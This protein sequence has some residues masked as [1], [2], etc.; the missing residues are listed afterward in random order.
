[1]VTLRCGGFVAVRGAHARARWQ[2]QCQMDAWCADES[3]RAFPGVAQRQGGW[4]AVGATGRVEARNWRDFAV[5]FPAS[6]CP[7]PWYVRAREEEREVA[8]GGPASSSAVPSVLSSSPASHVP[9]ARTCGRPRLRPMGGFAPPAACLI[10]RARF[11]FL[12][13]LFIGYARA[14]I[15]IVMSEVLR[16]FGTCHCSCRYVAV[17]S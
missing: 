2:S 16:L 10:N 4:H 3:P 11:S 7:W 5:P 1:M 6:W 9:L 13:R 14:I 8:P 17:A 12:F 15:W